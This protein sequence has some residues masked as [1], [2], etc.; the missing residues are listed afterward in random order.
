MAPA[1]VR[2]LVLP[3]LTLGPIALAV[4]CGGSTS[5]STTTPDT[6]TIAQACDDEAQAYCHQLAG[7]DGVYL[8]QELGSEADCET[9]YADYC[10]DR[11]AL[12][13][14]GNDAAHTES[15]A[16]ATAGRSCSDTSSSSACDQP[17][18]VVPDGGSCAAAG[19]CQSG[20]C[21]FSTTSSCG[22]CA[23]A[24]GEGDAC[25]PTYQCG[26][27]LTCSSDHTRCVAPLGVGESCG[28]ASR[29][30]DGLRCQG[31]PA[32]CAKLDSTAA[33]GA[34]C[35]ILDGENVACTDG[36]CN[37]GTCVA[38][39]KLGAACDRTEGPFC[40]YS[41]YCVNGTCV[42]PACM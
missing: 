23:D 6:A 29:C 10:N 17:T 41:T 1:F 35:G 13:G 15:C 31:T 18:G 11:L 22:T 12:P 9:S 7:C 36:S 30:A 8:A 32:V 16:Q 26:S 14:N 42:R 28:A 4:A 21:A 3:F 34:A 5:T 19:Q 38:N 40:G 2:V 25:T 37:G 20:F 24:P 39:A 27:K 33:P